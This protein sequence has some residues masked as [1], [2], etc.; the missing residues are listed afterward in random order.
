[1]ARGEHQSQKVVAD[2]VVDRG[3]EVGHAQLLPLF[4]LGQHLL[5]LSLEKFAAA[6]HVD[7]AVLGCRHEPGAG[8]IGDP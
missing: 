3:V 5:V 1:V 4:E 8:I 2:I 6:M 7:G